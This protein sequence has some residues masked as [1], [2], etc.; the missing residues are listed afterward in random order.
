MR[1]A[2]AIPGDLE[3][4]TGGYGYARRVIA[5]TADHGIT[6]AHLPLPGGFPGAG[7]DEVAEA[8]ARLGRV[9][10]GQPILLDGLAGGAL[11]GEAIARLAA[12]VVM[13]C[14]HPLALE[15]GLDPVEADILRR[16][17]RA[18]LTASRHVIASS[19]STAKILTRDY[20]VETDRITIARPGTDPAAPANGGDDET[21]RLLSVGSITR[22][23]GHDLVISALADMDDGRTAWQLRVVGAALDAEFERLLQD[24]IAEHGLEGR[25]HLTGPLGSADLEAEYARADLFVLASHFEGFGMAFVEAVARGLPVL[26]LASDAVAEATKGAAQLVPAE[27]FPDALKRLIS[28][29]HQR[30]ALAARSRAAAPTLQRWSETA[31]IIAET[32][33]QI[34]P[35]KA[36]A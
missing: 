13:L 26:G 20:D 34:T 28:D 29:R 12:P 6:L 36:T 16:T 17:E 35:Q 2:F 31:R 11:P 8:L 7:A 27:A 33:R 3:T 22:R 15:T 21:L 24:R 32:L 30:T 9:P 18:A 19:A 23:K 1:A 10:A 14:H 25:V 4:P 5:E